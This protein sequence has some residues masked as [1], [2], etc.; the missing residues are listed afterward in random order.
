MNLMFPAA[1]GQFPLPP[2]PSPTLQ[3]QQ[4][5]P[6][7]QQA[8]PSQ[9]P[10]QTPQAQPQQGIGA[11]PG[12]LRPPTAAQPPMS[13]PGLVSSATGPA[14]EGS[15]AHFPTLQTPGSAQQQPHPGFPPHHPLAQ[16]QQQLHQLQQ[17]QLQQQQQQ[18]QQQQQQQQQEFH[19]YCSLLE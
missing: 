16:Q 19:R 10:T 12:H 2:L 5:Q 4:Q 15:M 8:P 14:A 7:Q 3:Q 11:F 17:Q 18:L 9:P 1:E 6:G 13:L